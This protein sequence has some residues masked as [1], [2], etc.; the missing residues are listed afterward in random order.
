MKAMIKRALP[1]LLLAAAAS[2]N[3]SVIELGSVDKNY[4]SANGNVNPNTGIRKPCDKVTGNAVTVKDTA[5]GCTKFNDEFDFS[6]I[7]YKSID[8]FDLTL[9]FSNTNDFFK[10][11]KTK[12]YENWF[13]GVGDQADHVSS[14]LMSMTKSDAVISQTFHIDAASHADVFSNIASSGKFYLSFYDESWVV[15]DFTLRSASLRLN[16]SNIAADVPE[17]S[18]LALFGVAMLGAAYARRRRNQLM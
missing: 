9:S 18:S 6:T 16:G 10:L 17:P 7:D 8:S 13:V 12:T 1:A 2:A 15:S 14:S 5:S 11:G 4:G 3:A